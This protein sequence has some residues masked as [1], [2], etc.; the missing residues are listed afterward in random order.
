MTILVNDDI[1]TLDKRK[2][3]NTRF[4]NISNKCAVISR[5]DLKMP[6]GYFVLLVLVDS[7]HNYQFIFIFCNAIFFVLLSA[8]TA[9]STI[10]RIFYFHFYH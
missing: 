10:Y 1:I 2:Q 4:Y 9:T 6:N 8:N 3:N 5:I 7:K